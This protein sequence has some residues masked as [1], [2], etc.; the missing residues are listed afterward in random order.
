[1]EGLGS[2][3]MAVS[4]WKETVEDHRDVR[5]QFS[6]NIKGTPALM[7]AFTVAREMTNVLPHKAHNEFDDGI[8]LM[9][10]VQ[11]NSNGCL[12]NDNG[13]DMVCSADWTDFDSIEQLEN[14][15][16]R[17]KLT[18]AYHDVA[19]CNNGPWGKGCMRVG[20]AKCDTEKWVACRHE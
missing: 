16:D 3:G 4:G 19:Q 11:G 13:S 15:H 10:E 1:M 6:N 7:L 8:L 17:E 2:G 9:R 14:I 18:A 5:P 20:F 12:C